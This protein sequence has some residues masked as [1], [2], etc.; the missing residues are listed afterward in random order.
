MPRVGSDSRNQIIGMLNAGI[1]QP[2][3]ALGVLQSMFQLFRG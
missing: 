2:E 1:S 3:V